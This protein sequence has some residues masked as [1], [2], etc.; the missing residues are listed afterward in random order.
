[1]K[2]IKKLSAALLAVVMLVSML[3]C[4]VLS[5]AAAS[6]NVGEGPVTIEKVE[7]GSGIV[8]GGKSLPNGVRVVNSSWKGAKGDVT[9]KLG[10]V[11]YRCRM[12]ETAFAD[13][14]DASIAA[15]DNDT[16]Y[17]AAGVYESN[18]S[19]N[20]GGLKIYGPYAGVNPNDRYDLAWP[21]WERPAADSAN[22]GGRPAHRD[23]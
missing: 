13:L 4:M 22:P 16:I 5:T 23:F 15:K 2:N 8:V 12:G 7:G 21:N 11:A 17:V 18:I 10:G 1:M 14:I 20:V 19:I 3:S 6:F 9:I